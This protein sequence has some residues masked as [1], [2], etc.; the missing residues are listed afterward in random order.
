MMNK[1][2]ASNAIGTVSGI[3]DIFNQVAQ[4]GSLATAPATGGASLAF[5][6]G[7]PG[8]GSGSRGPFSLMSGPSSG[9][10]GSSAGPFSLMDPNALSS[11]GSY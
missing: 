11:F 4:I 1:A 10:F 8:M 2:Q 6:G 9:T 3:E 7:I 5:A